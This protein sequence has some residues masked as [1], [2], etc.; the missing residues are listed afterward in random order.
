MSAQV[1]LLTAQQTSG[2]E[3]KPTRPTLAVTLQG[4]RSKKPNSDD[5]IHQAEF[6][7]KTM[8]PG[9]ACGPQRELPFRP[10]GS[11]GVGEGRRFQGRRSHPK[12]GFSGSEH[13]DIRKVSFPMWCSKLTALVLIT[14]TA[15]AFFLAFSIHAARDTF[16]RTP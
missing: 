13:D 12:D 14:R 5:Q 3:A 1:A 15:F 2:P 6:K 4:P 7:S 9:H 16:E 8:M 10:L 11:P